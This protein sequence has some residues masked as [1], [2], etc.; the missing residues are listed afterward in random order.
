[1]IIRK[2]VLLVAAAAAIAAAAGVAVIAG[3]FALYAMLRD[4]L[5]SAGAAA[6]VSGL[7]ALLILI[8]ALTL[9]LMLRPHR[10]TKEVSLVQRALDFARDRPL[11]ALGGA[12]IVSLLAV[13]NPQ[14]LTTAISAFLAGN[15][16]PRK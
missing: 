3:A 4:T 6:A 10:P 13:R 16:R 9:L 7:A 8:G 11:I 12:A 1:M 2:L 14:L 5:G 15:A